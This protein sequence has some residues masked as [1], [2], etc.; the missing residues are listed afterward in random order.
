MLALAKALTLSRLAPPFNSIANECHK[1]FQNHT[2][3][4][5]KEAFEAMSQAD[6]VARYNSIISHEYKGVPTPKRGEKIFCWALNGGTLME[7]KPCI[8]CQ[9]LYSGWMLNEM[10]STIVRKMEALSTLFEPARTPREEV[11]CAE[12]LAAAHLCTLSQASVQL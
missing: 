7:V 6:A 5:N 1:E 2:K 9:S 12:T 11:Y 4:M 3:D 8:R 10:P